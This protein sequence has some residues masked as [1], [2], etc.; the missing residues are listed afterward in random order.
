MRCNTLEQEIAY[1]AALKTTYDS[2]RTLERVP[3]GPSGRGRIVDLCV[4]IASAPAR[5]LPSTM[6]SI[7]SRRRR[8]LISTTLPLPVSLKNGKSRAG[9]LSLKQSCSQVTAQGA[10]SSV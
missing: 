6:L 7:V 5:D 2:P 1:A 9:L 3:P 4:A 10:F 8:S